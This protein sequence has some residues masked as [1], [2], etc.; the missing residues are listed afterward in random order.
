MWQSSKI[1]AHCIATADYSNQLEEFL[2][3]YRGSKSKPNLG[4]LSK[5]DIPKGSGRKDERPPRKR[6]KGSTTCFGLLDNQTVTEQNASDVSVSSVNSSISDCPTSF[7]KRLP[8][9]LWMYMPM[10]NQ[11]NQQSCFHSPTMQS[12]F[13]LS[14]FLPY[15]QVGYQAWNAPPYV[16]LA[17]PSH[18]V[19]P[20]TCSPQQSFMESPR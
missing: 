2:T 9:H 11:Y 4:T 5:V 7:R 18:N 10:Q 19:P 8:P 12:N 16:P 15:S 1:Y 6:K 13:S 3:W 14:S 17:C 20:Q